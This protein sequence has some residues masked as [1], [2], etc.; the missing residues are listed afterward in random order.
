MGTVYGDLPVPYA[1]VSVLVLVDGDTAIVPVQ[2]EDRLE[3]HRVGSCR[4]H[5]RTR[6]SSPPPAASIPSRSRANVLLYGSGDVLSPPDLWVCDLGTASA[7][8]SPTRG[9]PTG[10]C[11][12][13]SRSSAAGSGRADGPEVQVKFMRPHG[14]TGPLP[15]VLIV[16]GGPY[17]AFGEVFNADAQLLCEAGY[18][19]L[20]PTLAARAA[21]GSHSRARS[22]ATGATSTTTT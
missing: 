9:P 5:V 21:T 10:R 2:I 18:G 3:I 11:C 4:A 7:G 13:P 15:T 19:V 6:S 16:H 20:S 22:T 1:D 14:T 17:A 12:A 8:R